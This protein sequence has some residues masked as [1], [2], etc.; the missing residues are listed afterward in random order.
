MLNLTRII[1]SILDESQFGGNEQRPLLADFLNNDIDRRLLHMIGPTA[2]Q[3][4]QSKTTFAYLATPLL[5]SM[6]N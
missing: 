1:Q 3:V 2:F 6:D 4:I 5:I